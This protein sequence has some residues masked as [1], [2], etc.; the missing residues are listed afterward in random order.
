MNWV[1]NLLEELLS[2]GI[3]VIKI[4]QENH[5]SLQINLLKKKVF[6]QG[7]ENI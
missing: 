5:K 4:P 1:L 7:I 6:K 3:L 2:L